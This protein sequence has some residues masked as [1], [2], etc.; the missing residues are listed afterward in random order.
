MSLFSQHS[1]D[2]V[3]P[4]SFPFGPTVSGNLDLSLNWMG[5]LLLLSGCLEAPMPSSSPSCRKRDLLVNQK[6]IKGCSQVSI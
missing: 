2:S 4:D 5:Q 3:V 1:G 6:H